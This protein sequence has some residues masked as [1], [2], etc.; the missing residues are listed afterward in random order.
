M[1]LVKTDH[2]ADVYRLSDRSGFRHEIE[3]L[4]SHGQWYGFY[5]TVSANE[6]TCNPLHSCGP[7]QGWVRA[8]VETFLERAA[9]DIT[10][11]VKIEHILVREA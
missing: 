6:I 5:W 1:P 9:A 11:T 10:G 7:T 2:V 8:R 4:E 3:I